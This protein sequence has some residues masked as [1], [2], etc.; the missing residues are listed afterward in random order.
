MDESTRLTRLIP[1]MLPHRD[2][3]LLIDQVESLTVWKQCVAY[4]HI[5]VDDEVFRGHFPDQPIYPG[6]LILE[7]LAQSA[8]FLLQVSRGATDG[9]GVLSSVD[10]ARFIKPVA[11]GSVLRCQVSLVHKK[12]PFFFSYGE[13]FVDDILVARSKLSAYFHLHASS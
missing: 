6:V 5:A 11:P 7:S 12:P 3:F 13:A 9:Y 1:E 2:P 4:N 10:K 8:G